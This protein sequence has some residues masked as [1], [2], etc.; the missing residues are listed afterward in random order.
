MKE[1]LIS[2]NEAGQRFDKYIA[3]YLKTAPSSFIYKMLRK[4]N[5]TL[6]GKKAEGS[7]KLVVSDKVNFFLS[8][9]TIEAFKNGTSPDSRTDKPESKEVGILPPMPPIVYE[10]KNILI[11]NKP[12]GLLSQKAEKNDISANE[13]IVEYLKEKYGIG[14]NE[15]FTPGVCNRLDRNT[16]GLLIAGKSLVGAQDISELLKKRNIHK[17]YLTIVRGRVSEKKHSKAYL[18]RNE[19]NNKSEVIGSAEFE[20]IKTADPKLAS[21]YDMVETE[22]G[23]LAYKDGYTL[24]WV[25]LITGKTHQIRAHLALMGLPLAGDVK[26]RDGEKREIEGGIKRQMLHAYMLCFTEDVKR[27]TEI[28]NL[29]VTAKLPED[30]EKA[31]CRL[32]GKEVFEDAVMEFKRS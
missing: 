8:D 18:R 17:Y 3:K 29:K 25:L 2:E 4:K 32:F 15:A 1:V 5:I 28:K 19:K 16:S 14:K 7:E 22:F 10:D 20:K 24:L 12:A 23:P 26:Y 11:I 21:E 27:L 30:F 31:G 13:I 6:N 9:E